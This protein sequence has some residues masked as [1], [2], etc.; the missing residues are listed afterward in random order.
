MGGTVELRRAEV[1]VEEKKSRKGGRRGRKAEAPA[2][3][4]RA[5]Y[6]ITGEPLEAVGGKVWLDRELPPGGADEYKAQR[7]RGVRSFALWADPY[8]QNLWARVVTASANEG[9]PVRYE[10]YGGSGEFI[11]S[12]SRQG[13]FAGGHIRTR[14]TVEQQG[15]PSA[16]GYKGR[17]FWWCVWWLI[18]PLQCVIG[19]AALLCADGDVFQ[20]PRRIG[21]RSEGA[22]VLDYG[23]GL[24]THFHLTAETADWDPRLLACLLALHCSHDGIMGGSWD[25]AGG[26]GTGGSSAS[27]A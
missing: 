6:Q 25:T 15:G 5:W 13:G 22:R 24:D 10:V 16:V 9:E 23:S 20:V 4:G 21:Y 12:A 8:R 1:P 26:F 14:W 19:V 7:K 27:A 3:E 11:G 17:W 18:F 2:G